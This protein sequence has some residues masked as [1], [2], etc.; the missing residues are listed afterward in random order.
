MMRPT[1]KDLAKAA[2]VSLAT[3]DRVINKR[4]NVSNKSVEK[5][6][7]AIENIGFVRNLSAVNLARNRIYK[8]LF[9]L[10]YLGDQYLTELQNQVEKENRHLSAD[11]VVLDIVQIDADNPH[12]VANYL[13]KLD[14]KNIDGVAIMTPESPQVRDAMVRLRD[15]GIKLVQFLS[16]QEN[17]EDTDFVGIDNFAAGATAGRIIGSCKANHKGKIL[18]IAETMQ[19]QD[20][21]ERRIGFDNFINTKFKALNCLPSLETYADPIRAKRIIEQSFRYNNDIVAVYVMSSEAR[22]PLTAVAESADL[23]SL[24][25]VVHERT[26][27]TEK[28]IRSEV[29]DAIIGQ[30]PGHAVR[31]AVRIMRTH[32]HFI[33]P[34][35]FQDKIQIEVLFKENL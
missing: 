28:A 19:T 27:F 17:L 32:T 30:N 24:T 2:G 35:A 22:I 3:V 8:F 31:S 9:I 16:G 1:V 4:A 11:L 33:K 15:R 5:V 25:I 10:P 6:A 7:E 13:S 12:Y 18:I 20:S 29:I 21:I 23:E 26:P 14:A 34:I